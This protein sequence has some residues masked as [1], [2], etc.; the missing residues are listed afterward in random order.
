MD[1]YTQTPIPPNKKCKL[2]HFLLSNFLSFGI[3]VITLG[4]WF[5]YN[6]YYALSALLLAFIF[7]GIVRSKLLHSS[8][9]KVQQEFSYSDKDIAAWYLHLYVC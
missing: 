5:Y 7:M 2:L 4:V 9:P 8:V 3:Y 6:W 1:L